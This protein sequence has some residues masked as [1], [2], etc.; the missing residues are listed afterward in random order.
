[1]TSDSGA[2]LGP[3]VPREISVPAVLCVGV[4]FIGGGGDTVGRELKSL[5]SSLGFAPRR[6]ARAGRREF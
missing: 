3:G 4:S 5:T 1:M 2:E 6:R